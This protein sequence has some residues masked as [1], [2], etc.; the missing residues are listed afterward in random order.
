MMGRPIVY[1]VMRNTMLANGSVTLSVPRRAVASNPAT[2]SSRPPQA[3]SAHR[4][5]RPLV[6]R[7]A[8]RLFGRCRYAE[9]V[10]IDLA[11]VGSLTVRSGRM[12]AGNN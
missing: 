10:A 8:A 2:F 9:I 11:T 5:S 12:P 3:A 4:S 7:A 1:P 6:T